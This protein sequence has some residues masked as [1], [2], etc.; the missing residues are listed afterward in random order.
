MKKL[1]KVHF[2]Q[3][4][5]VTIGTAIYAFG[6]VEFNMGNHLAEGGVAGLSLIGYALLNIDP[7]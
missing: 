4:L 3:L 6:F 1:S 7:S 2:L 5:A